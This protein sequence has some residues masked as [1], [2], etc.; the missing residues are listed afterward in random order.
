MQRAACRDCVW[1]MQQAGQKLHSSRPA[2]LQA[3]CPGLPAGRRCALAA[4]VTYPMAC[5]TT[6]VLDMLPGC[7]AAAAGLMDYVLADYTW[8]RAV[9]LLGPTVATLGM[10][11]QIPL[12]TAADVVLSW[13][14]LGHPHWMDSRRATL[15]TAA[16]T[17]AIL[18]GVFG[19]N[20]SGGSDAGSDAGGSSGGWQAGEQAGHIAADGGLQERFLQAGDGEGQQQHS[21]GAVQ[22]VSA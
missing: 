15:L 18:A 14:G 8:A 21:E 2:G 5:M 9:L 10:T 6:R 17:V 4:T 13:T 11:V 19:I 1:C 22:S 7:V 3:P 12:A 20:C 16:G